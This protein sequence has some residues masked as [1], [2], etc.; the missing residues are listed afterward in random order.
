MHVALAIGSLELPAGLITRS[1]GTEDHL[2]E[3]ER[4]LAAYLIARPGEDVSRDVLLTEVLG[5]SPQAITRAVDDGIRRLRAKIER[6]PERPF[7]L[8]GLR[9]V[10]YRFVPLQVASE[11]QRRVRAGERIIDLDRLEVTGGDGAATQLSATE[12]R[13]LEVLLAHSGKPVPIESLLRDVWG[14]RDAR[15]KKLVDKAVY[16]LRAKVET[17][18]RDPRYL[19]TVRGRG[20]LLDAEPLAPEVVAA[21]APPSPGTVAAH[22]APWRRPAPRELVGRGGD[23]T[24]L[25]GLLAAPGALVTVHGAAGL[26]KTSLATAVCAAWAGP[27]GFCDLTSVSSEAELL[28]ELVTCLG[29]DQSETGPRDALHAALRAAD[30]GLL[31]FDNAET[32]ADLLSSA[33]ADIRT[34]A[35]NLRVLVTSRVLLRAPNEAV[36]ALGP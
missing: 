29:V 14:I 10:G 20:L 34:Q 11:G 19:K 21:D 23:R 4:D 6:L 32:C 36:L 26:G 33:L 2:T 24:R 22:D 1:D 8:V 16:R 31:V 3:Q 7:H 28:T 30:D 18:P 17:D 35:S 15:R 25:E 27:A 12:G 9:G 13:L 5:Y